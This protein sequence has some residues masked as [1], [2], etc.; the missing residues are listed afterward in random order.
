MEPWPHYRAEAMTIGEEELEKSKGGSGPTARCLGGAHAGEAGKGGE[1]W[2][3]GV[4]C[5]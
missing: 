2:D 5:V 4:G 3:G 1:A